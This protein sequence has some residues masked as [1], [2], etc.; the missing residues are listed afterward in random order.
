MSKKHY[1][2][3]VSGLGDE[4]QLL[5]WATNHYRQYELEPVIHNIWWRKGERHFIPKLQKLIKLID[6]LSKNGSLVSLV[7][8][9]AGS[10]AVLNAFVKRKSKICKVISICGRLRQGDEEGFR[11]F[12]FRSASSLAFKESVLMFEK[13]EPSIN[14]DDRKKIMTV[15]AM[16]DELVPPKTVIVQGALNKRIPM[17]EHVLSIATALLVYDPVIRFLKVSK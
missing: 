2:I 7:G 9:S 17:V 5:K 10:S 1:V 6:R 14:K 15:R 12:K 3:I 16:F 13:S 8:T 11:S 4:A